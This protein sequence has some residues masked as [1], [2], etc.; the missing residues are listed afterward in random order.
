M[1]LKNGFIS[2]GKYTSGDTTWRTVGPNSKALATSKGVPVEFMVKLSNWRG[3]DDRD[4]DY[5]DNNGGT[6]SRC[7]SNYNGYKVTGIGLGADFI[8]T[9][10]TKV[11]YIF[12]MI[13]LSSPI[14]LKEDSN[15]DFNFKRVYY[16]WIALYCS[17]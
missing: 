14:T 16:H 9:Y 4:N 10:G 17:S 6:S 1:V 2:S 5:C 11:N 12:Y 15:G 7:E 3:I 8:E 13:K